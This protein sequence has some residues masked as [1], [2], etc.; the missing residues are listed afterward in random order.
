MHGLL[1]DR[2]ELSTSGDLASLLSLALGP[3]KE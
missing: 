3:K 2:T 1:K